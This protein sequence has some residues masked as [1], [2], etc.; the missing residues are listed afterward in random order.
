MR[1][2][3]AAE[4]GG[5]GRGPP[6]GELPL[7]LA[8]DCAAVLAGVEGFVAPGRL[9]GELVP[10]ERDVLG[11]VPGAF[12]GV[13][14]RLIVVPAVLDREEVVRVGDGFGVLVADD[15]APTVED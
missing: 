3:A 8:R 5:A 13:L 15:D 2:D 4:V 1:R 10:A 6:L 12:V 7:A 14:V 11:V 9:D